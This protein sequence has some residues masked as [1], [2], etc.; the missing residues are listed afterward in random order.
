MNSLD[1]KIH[2][3]IVEDE[4]LIADMLQNCLKDLGYN[5]IGVAR[6]SQETFQLIESEQ[7]DI[8]IL[9]IGI[10]GALNGIQVAEKINREQNLPFIF[11]TALNDSATIQSAVKTNPYGYL[12]K[13]FNKEELYAAIEVALGK[14]NA[15]RHELREEDLQEQEYLFIKEKGVFVKV[16]KLD[17]LYVKADDK[18]IEVHVVGRKYVLRRNLSEFLSLLPRNAFLQTHRSYIVN[19]MEINSIGAN[20]VKLGEVE[21]PMSNS[22][23]EAIKA[24]FDFLN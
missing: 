19:V 22:R 13:P 2:V 14:Y 11:L 1:H 20:F 3:L 9:D 4:F 6:D 21:I 17:I 8:V 15:D 24:R 12:I 5:V 10:K 23:K 16:K 7:I 18:Y